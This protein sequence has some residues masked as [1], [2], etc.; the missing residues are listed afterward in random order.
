MRAYMQTPTLELVCW[1]KS[2]RALSPSSPLAYTPAHAGALPL[3]PP[4]QPPVHIRRSMLPFS[5]SQGMQPPLE[6]ATPGEH[7][8][9]Q[10][11]PLLSEYFSA[12]ESMMQPLQENMKLF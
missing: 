4:S 11:L 3:P 1:S 9:P 6:Y 5:A 12:L 8:S 7:T 10:G 2:L